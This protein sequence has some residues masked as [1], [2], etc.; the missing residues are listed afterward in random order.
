M[1][2]ST[3]APGRRRGL[4]VRGKILAVGAAGMAAAIGLGTFAMGELGDSGD[5][6]EQVETIGHPRRTRPAIR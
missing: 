5:A 6:L 1:T 4:G 2:H 3:T